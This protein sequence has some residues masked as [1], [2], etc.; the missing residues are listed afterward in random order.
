MK[1]GAESLVAAFA[2]Y[3]AELFLNAFDGDPP[4]LDAGTALV[5]KDDQLGAAIGRVRL[6]HDVI[7]GLELIHKFTHRLWRD[8]RSAR[9]VGKPRPL[10]LDL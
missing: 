3:V 1:Q 9:E 4:G 2:Q 6:A 10:G 5:R 8:V 7:H